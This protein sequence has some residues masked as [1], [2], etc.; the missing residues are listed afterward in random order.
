MRTTRRGSVPI[1]D[2]NAR[3]GVGNRADGE[4]QEPSGPANRRVTDDHGNMD[5]HGWA[6]DRFTH[7]LTDKAEWIEVVPVSERGTSR[8]R[9]VYDTEDDSQR[10]HR[11]LYVCDECGPGANADCN[12]AENVRNGGTPESITDRDNG[13]SA[14]PHS[15]DSIRR[16]DG[17]GHENRRAANR[18]LPPPGNPHSQRSRSR[19]AKH[20]S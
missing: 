11:G 10:V 2:P 18:T 13:C 6:F 19:G 20:R 15:A 7:L 8:T 9:S 14:Q 5:L 3:V 4:Q 16:P 17:S 1:A 12:G